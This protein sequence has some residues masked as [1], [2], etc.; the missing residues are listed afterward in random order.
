[1][2]PFHFLV[3]LGVL[4]ITLGLI[5]RSLKNEFRRGLD[6]FERRLEKLDQRTRSLTSRISEE[7]SV[8][9]A[10]QSSSSRDYKALDERIG[11]IESALKKEGVEPPGFKEVELDQAAA[12]PEG[13]E[14]IVL[15]LIEEAAIQPVQAE[16]IPE[17]EPAPESAE[18]PPAPPLTE[19]PAQ[20]I[21]L[22]EEPPAVKAPTWTAS[23]SQQWWIG[24]ETNVGK[25]WM[26]WAG[27][28]ALFLAAGFFVKYAFE[29][30]WLGPTGRVVLGMLLGV[31]LA[32]AGD[33]L[34][35]RAMPVLGQGLIGG[36]IAV[37]YVSLFAAFAIYK[38]VPQAVA[39]AAMAAVTVAGMTL[40]ILH[41]AVALGFLAVLGGFLTPIMISTGQDARD[42]LFSYLTVLNLGVLGVAIFK[43]WRALDVLT[44]VGTWLF[45]AGW[46]HTFYRDTAL[47]PTTLWAALFFVIF[48]AAPFITQL[49]AKLELSMESVAMI[50]ANAAVAFA[51]A[52]FMLSRDARD[53]VFLY[54][55]FIDLIVL[56][57]AIFKR[58][59]ALDVMAFAG[60]WAIFASWYFRF[61]LDAA[62][63]GTSIWVAVFFIIF[64]VISFV[65]QLRTKSPSPI[66]SICMVLSDAVIAFIFAYLMLKGEYRFLQAFVALG[67]A[68][69]Y[70]AMA[71]LVRRRIPEDPVTLFGFVGIAVAFL[72]L[73]VPLQ[74]KLHGITL[75]W[76]VEGPVLLY[77]GY[78][79]NYRPVRIAGAA[80]LVLAGLKMLATVLEPGAESTT[81]F[82]NPRFASAMSVPLFA[83][84]Y[85]TV[86]HIRRNQATELDE[87]LMRG[88]II[89][90][91]FLAMIVMSV[92]IDNWIELVARDQR[93][94][95]WYLS[96]SATV[97]IWSL[98]AA[99]FLAGSL[100]GGI[101][102]LF[103]AGVAS[104]AIAVFA[105][106]GSYSHMKGEGYLL[107]INVR[108]IV[109]LLLAA[110]ILLCARIANGFGGLFPED[111]RFMAVP[112]FV[113]LGIFPLFLLSVE[114]YNYCFAKIAPPVQAEQTGQMALSIVWGLYAVASLAVGFIYRSRHLRIAALALLGITALKVLVVDMAQVQQ[115]YRIVSFV[116]LGLSMIAVSYLYHRLERLLEGS[117]GETK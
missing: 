21:P 77:L 75:A 101:S 38:L 12:A 23:S 29:N 111:K 49:R 79:Y 96:F 91:G 67:L 86:H 26:T 41:D 30:E 52:Y 89:F 110:V 28:L 60:T 87:S 27:V 24:F 4:A 5:Y 94:S 113:C 19:I 100:R 45:F 53:V 44:F 43:R 20:H 107:F 82:L 22:P 90:A 35:R 7:E 66:E 31:V 54:V 32:A 64:L 46:F 40:A 97:I 80:V 3:G 116:V 105:L 2:D 68:G 1:M 47:V 72:T 115:I 33:Y 25:R 65:N 99:G 34:A 57:I 51:V 98:G 104:L 8:A 16:R 59:R 95:Y 18:V 62:I 14:E 112:M 74:L 92:E 42:A 88:G 71:V 11:W 108:F 55:A 70:V 37:L 109:G 78:I 39:F 76:A 6:K 17:C 63:V 58:W 114:A 103:Y 50:V 15:D 13:P 9:K 83:A 102:A 81:A 61:Y 84:I 106:I 69:C 10:I 36:G 48:L 85:S 117:V 93:I 56:G 73:A